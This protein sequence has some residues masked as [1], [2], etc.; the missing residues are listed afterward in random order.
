MDTCVINELFG[1]EIKI[2]RELVID[3]KIFIDNS[4]IILLL[5]VDIFVSLSGYVTT[6]FV[7]KSRKRG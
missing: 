3:T 6:L 5:Y 2:I 4:R 1:I 7:I